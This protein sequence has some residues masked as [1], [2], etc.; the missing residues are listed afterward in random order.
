MNYLGNVIYRLMK[1]DEEFKYDKSGR[2]DEKL[3]VAE[4]DEE[5]IIEEKKE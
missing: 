3:M 5:Y 1:S 4:D 2:E